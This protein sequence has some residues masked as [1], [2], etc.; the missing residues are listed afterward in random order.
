MDWLL[1]FR[2]PADGPCD[3]GLPRRVIRHV[4]RLGRISIGSRVLLTG[5]SEQ[6]ARYLDEMAIDAASL[7]ASPARS[8]H[9]WFAA[10][11]SE[12]CADA[13]ISHE[14]TNRCDLLGFD[15]LRETAR[16]ATRL[17]PGGSLILI[18][19]FDPQWS[20]PGGHLETCYRRHLE[21]FPG[22]C[23]VS[24]LADSFVSRSTWNWMLGR[25]PRAG[26]LIA[27]LQ[28]PTAVRLRRDWEQIA[29]QAALRRSGCCCSWGGQS[30]QSTRFAA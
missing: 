11:S 27:S 12:R 15:A 7:D 21:C 22:S 17:L 26:F 23:Q 25:Q 3:P 14:T 2:P 4:L 9:G 8:S 5:F 6:L 20:N 30:A 29:D 28:I 1:P 10:R 19:R 24:C 18:A 13:L 16:L